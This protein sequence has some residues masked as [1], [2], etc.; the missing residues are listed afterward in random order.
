MENIE[1]QNLLVKAI[2]EASPEGILVV[3]D[4]GVVIHHNRRFLEVWQFPDELPKQGSAIGTGHGSLLSS[5]CERLEDP[6]AFLARVRELYDNP[7]LDDHCEIKLRNGSTLERVSTVLRGGDGRYLGRVWYF[8][9]ITARKQIED[10]LR[11]NRFVSE[12]A[13]ECIIWADEQARIV[14]ANE[15]AC[16]AYGYTK[17]ELL[18]KTVI[19][20]DCNARMAGWPD[21]WRA[22]REKGNANFETWHLR[23]DGSTFPI[24]CIVNFI[25]FE[26][27]ELIIGFYRDISERRQVEDK[28]LITQFVSDNAPDSIIWIDERGRIVYVNE[29][30]CRERGYTREE[31]LAKTIPD[32]NPELPEDVWSGHW[33]RSRQK[34]TLTFESRHRRKDG[35]TFP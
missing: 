25:K 5:V 16:R 24:E 23:K 15:A 28:L 4:K 9:D 13:P 31:L 21:H 14:Y 10:Q 1:L 3:D 17:N 12:H 22:L 8:L 34:G 11:I 26:G 29:E 30:A 19:D 27:R 2:N 6:D 32:I 35:S 18:A 33:Q 7:Q 20:I